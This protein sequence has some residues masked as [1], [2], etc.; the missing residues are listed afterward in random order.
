M[1]CQ[2]LAIWGQSLEL[3]NFCY[4]IFN[5]YFLHENVVFLVFWLQISIPWPSKHPETYFC[6][7][8][9]SRPIYKDT[10]KFALAYD[11][12]KKSAPMVNL[13][14]VVKI[15]TG[16]NSRTIGL[17]DIEKILFSLVIIFKNQQNIA[18]ENKEILKH[19]FFTTL[20]RFTFAIFDWLTYNH[21]KIVHCN[22][23]LICWLVSKITGTSSHLLYT[24]NISKGVVEWKRMGTAFPPLFFVWEHVPTPF[25]TRLG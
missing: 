22:A 20:Y 7:S 2:Q 13:H 9:Q 10:S 6:A 15:S 16:L 4:K 24:C 12:Q 18:Y 11:E 8:M 23:A 3:K 21:G 17:W 14:L 25:C 1:L 19:L 5:L